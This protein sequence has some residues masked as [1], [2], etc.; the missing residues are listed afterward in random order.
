M[1]LGGIVAGAAGNLIG[2]ALGGLFKQPGARVN[3]APQP[4]EKN[5][6]EDVTRSGSEQQ[7]T[8]GQAQSAQIGNQQ[9]RGFAQSG[10]GTQGQGLL[11]QLAGGLSGTQ[12]SNGSQAHNQI[13]A[14]RMG[15]NTLPGYQAEL[16]DATRDINQTLNSIAHRGAANYSTGYA[17]RAGGQAQDRFADR[18]YDSYNR[19]LLANENATL[20]AAERGQRQKFADYGSLAGILNTAPFQQVQQSGQDNVTRQNQISQ[21]QQNAQRQHQD[22]M[23]SQSHEDGFNTAVNFQP[24]TSGLAQGLG[25]LTS[26]GGLETQ[27]GGSVGGD[28]LQHLFGG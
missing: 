26:I 25:L 10:L 24:R 2:G 22:Q 27:G 7:M 15:R 3:S 18:L 21:E 9:Q 4:Y 13:T 6:S 12:L 16:G 5:F 11:D 28:F 8:T 19:N 1:V 17:G 20:E 23:N 14:D